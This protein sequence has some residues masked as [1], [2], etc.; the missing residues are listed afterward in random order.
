MLEPTWYK[1]KPS[2]IKDNFVKVNQ[3]GLDRVTQALNNPFPGK[4]SINEGLKPINILRNRYSNI[5]PWDYTRVKLPVKNSANDYINA[6]H[7]VLDHDLKYIAT[8]GPKDQTIHHFWSMC[9]DQANKSCEDTIIIVMITPLIENNMIKCCKYWPD[10]ID[11]V[12]DLSSDVQ[13]DGIDL[14]GLKLS[15]VLELET[16]HYVLT[17]LSLMTDENHPKTVFHFHFKNWADSQVPLSGDSLSQLLDDISHYK[18]K[19]N[20]S[21]PIIHCSAGVGRTGTFI[22]LDYL[23]R[24]QSLLTESA[25]VG[26][27]IFKVFSSLRDQRVMMI[28]NVHQ[29][30]F[31]YD[32]FKALVGSGK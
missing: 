31:L 24:H 18:S 21:T 13:M 10:S 8:Q 23:K 29:Y 25:G 7:I 1:L 20:V 12:F 27:P 3:L 30:K 5:F 9:Y 32:Y 15:Y 19:Y 26:D 6:S 17:Q 22:A 16:P 4:F 11:K 2:S 28:Q 14:D